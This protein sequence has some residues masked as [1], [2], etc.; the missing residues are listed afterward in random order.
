MFVLLCFPWKENKPEANTAC[1]STSP[2]AVETSNSPG[3]EGFPVRL[4]VHV[5]RQLAARAQG[6]QSP[7][8]GT[9][10]DSPALGL[11]RPPH[12]PLCP[13]PPHFCLGELEASRKEGLPEATQRARGGAR[14]RTP[15]PRSQGKVVEAELGLSPRQHPAPRPWC[16]EPPRCLLQTQGRETRRA[17]PPYPF[18]SQLQHH[19]EP[20]DPPCDLDKAPRTT[21]FPECVMWGRR[22]PICPSGQSR[23]ACRAQRTRSGMALLFPLGPHAWRLGQVTGRPQARVFPGSVAPCVLLTVVA[24]A[25]TGNNIAN[26]AGGEMEAQGALW[27]PRLTS[28]VLG[29]AL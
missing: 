18:P 22:V 14:V 11:P 26:M 12:R 7:P 16:T 21:V 2:G 5:Q 24:G 9:G 25:R 19:R 1:I 29:R 17:Q 15:S 4:N 27:R 3:Q 23:H 20:L 10:E 28:G 6:E 8:Q 13:H